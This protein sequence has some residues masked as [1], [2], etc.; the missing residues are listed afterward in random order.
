[1]EAAV[2]WSYWLLLQR[3]SVDFFVIVVFSCALLFM[4][5]ANDTVQSCNISE[6][7]AAAPRMK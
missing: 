3:S 5:G 2:A 7:F 6:A 4:S 1:M